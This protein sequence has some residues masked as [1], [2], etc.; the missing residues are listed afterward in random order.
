M[1]TTADISYVDKHY[2]LTRVTQEEIFSFYMRR[3]LNF[4]G[5]FRSPLRKDKEPTCTI[6]YH[7]DKLYFRDWAE[8]KSLD[9][10]DFVGRL[11]KCSY[12]ATLD[13]IVTDMGLAGREPNKELPGVF[14]NGG[15]EVKSSK[16]RIRVS[17]QGFTRT[18]ADYLKQFYITRRVAEYYRCFSIER[19]WLERRPHYRYRAED[20]AIG[21]FLGTDG[22]GD[23][24]WKVYFYKRTSSSRF[25]GNTNRIN[26]WIQLP[27]RGEV[28]IITKSMKDVMVL[29]HFGIPAIAMQSEMTMP[30]R[31]IIDEL[32]RRFTR[33]Y[34]LYD[35]DRA[36]VQGAQRIRNRY[37]IPALFLTNGR[38]G[39]RDFGAKDISDFIRD[40]GI[41]TTERLL[42]YVAKRLF[43]T[44]NPCYSE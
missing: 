29:S 10:F 23:Q 18:D 5:K 42:R 13:H 7:G 40:R 6:S 11:H 4:R 34:T 31:E 39:T 24:R 14:V 38:F 36:G 15:N 30:Y 16:K 12:G 35:F 26:G 8:N 37:E 28:L 44:I 1:I 25:I 22:S 20:P 19:V 27:E 33:I 2:V 3:P 41:D 21:Y 32:R 43:L 17:I 9:C